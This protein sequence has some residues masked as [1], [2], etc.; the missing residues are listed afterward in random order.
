MVKAATNRTTSGDNGK[1]TEDD[2]RQ[3]LLDER[4]Q[5]EKRCLAELQQA[6][7]PILL[8]YK[9]VLEPQIVLRRGKVASEWYVEAY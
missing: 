2:A 7:K 1:L 5:R 6:T 4:L 8:K 9:C 3:V